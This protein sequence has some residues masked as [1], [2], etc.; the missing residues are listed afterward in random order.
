MNRATNKGGLNK[1]K[2]NS[3]KDYAYFEYTPF[4]DPR[5]IKVARPNNTP[6]D[7]KDVVY[8][9]STNSIGVVLGCIDVISEEL[10]TDVDGMQFFDN[11]E[12]ATPAHFH[13]PNV[14][15][16]TKLRIELGL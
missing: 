3:D 4:I 8:V 1:L 6:Y 12:P 13:F 10:R 2:V 5:S 14:S 11:I 9:K 16:E 15:V 7:V